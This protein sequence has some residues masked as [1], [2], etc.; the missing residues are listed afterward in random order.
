[1]EKEHLGSKDHFYLPAKFWMNIVAGKKLNTTK[2]DFQTR[3]LDCPH[4][5]AHFGLVT[6]LRPPQWGL[7]VNTAAPSPVLFLPFSP[8]LSFPFSLFSLPIKFAKF[9]LKNC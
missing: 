6:L 3:S 2:T 4:G 5:W 1:M 7:G 9:K 8:L